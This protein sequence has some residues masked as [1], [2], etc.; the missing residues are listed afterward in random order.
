MDLQDHKQTVFANHLLNHYLLKTGDYSGLTVFKFYLLYRATVR[1]KVAALRLQQQ[2]D[3]LIAYKRSAND[4]RNY[5][6]LAKSYTQ[7]DVQMGSVF[8]AISFGLSGSGKSRVCS[9]LADQS[10][11]IQ[12]CSDVERKRLFST[13]PEELYSHST[14]HKTYTYLMKLSELVLSAGY[15]VIVD[16]TFL[17]KKWRHQFCLIAQ[18]H[19]IPFHI[20]YCYAGQKTIK[21]RLRLRQDEINQISD[22]DISVMESQLKTMD[23]LDLDEKKVE[24]PVDT[25]QT[26]DFPSI[27]VQLKKN[28]L[29]SS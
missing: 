24:L 1:A 7:T 2:K 14:T 13:I 22:A 27:L 26:L 16:A 17:D 6:D 10:G 18:K 4:L 28:E 20:L 11:A 8:L 9:Q 3:E 5:L 29:S 21:Q 25:E 12:L 19:Q 23:S 15:S